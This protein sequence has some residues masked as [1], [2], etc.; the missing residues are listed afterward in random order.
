M[1]HPWLAHNS[2]AATGRGLAPAQIQ[3]RQNPKP[4]FKPLCRSK[5]N[6]TNAAAR[7]PEEENSTGLQFCLREKGAA[8]RSPKLGVLSLHLEFLDALKLSPLLLLKA[9]QI[10]PSNVALKWA[11]KSSHCRLLGSNHP[12]QG[13]AHGKREGSR[14]HGQ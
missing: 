13:M 7:F 2:P 10:C 9:N 14:A 8:D 4:G 12:Q 6:I 5:Q 11:S 1:L 3:P